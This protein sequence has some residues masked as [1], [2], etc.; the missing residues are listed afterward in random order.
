MKLLIT[1]ATG[2]IGSELV[3]QSVIDPDIEEI[4][5]LVRHPSE[6]VHPKITTVQHTDFLNYSPAKDYFK[7]ADAIIWCLG[8][9]QTQVSRKKYEIITYDYLQACVRFCEVIHPSIRFIFVSGD[10]ADRTGKSNVLFKRIK[11]KAENELLYSALKDF[12]IV[13]PDAV[14]PKHKNKK[15]PFAYKLV[16]PLFSL[17]ERFSPGHIIWSDV[18]GRALVSLAKNGNEKNTLENIELRELG[19]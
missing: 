16:Y 18:L 1:G 19:K 7:E 6:I 9:S 14:N 2:L 17:I 15:A 3:R 4:I 12:F 11:G 13:R 8:I 5:L 10:G